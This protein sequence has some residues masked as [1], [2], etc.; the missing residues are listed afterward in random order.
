MARYLVHN[1]L[2]PFRGAAFSGA[3]MQEAGYEE[4]Q[5]ADFE[6]IDQATE[7]AD[8]LHAVVESGWLVVHSFNERV[9]YDSRAQQRVG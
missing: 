7:C 8:K 2:V 9:L 4:G 1:A 5:V 6:T 3:A